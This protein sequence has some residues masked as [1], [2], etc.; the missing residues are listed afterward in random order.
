MQIWSFSGT[1]SVKE[2]TIS[3]FW[4]I[5]KSERK[6]KYTVSVNKKVHLFWFDS[7]PYRIVHLPKYNGTELADW[8][9]IY[10]INCDVLHGV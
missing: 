3:I 2:L 8:S 10:V 5:K 6:F 7:S 9:H 4:R 1:Q